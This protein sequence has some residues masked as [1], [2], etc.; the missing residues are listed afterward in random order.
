MNFQAVVVNVTDLKR[1]I[2]FY[3]E[4]LGFT[5]LSQAEQ[6]AA[7]SASGT[8]RTQ[9][10]VLREVGHSPLEGGGH[11]GLRAFVLEAESAEHLEKVAS[12]LDSRK[13]L[14]SRREMDDWTAVVGRDPDG[15][16]VVVAWHPDRGDDRSP[17]VPDAF[18]YGLGE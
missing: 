5:V 9:V 17:R 11:I 7:V 13:L 3:G 18:L 15:V 2:E 1:S 6:L 14:V 16:S 10:I 4:V 12:D 8:D